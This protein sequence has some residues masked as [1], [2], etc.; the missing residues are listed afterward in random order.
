MTGKEKLQQRLIFLDLDKTLFDT[1]RFKEGL[2][3]IFYECGGPDF[4]GTYQKNRLGNYSFR[5]HLAVIKDRDKRNKVRERVETLLSDSYKFL[6]PDAKDFLNRFKNDHLVLLTRGDKEF[7]KKKIFNLGIN[8]FTVFSQVI[9]TETSKADMV[10]V[11]L[12][13]RFKDPGNVFF[14]DDTA[15]EIADIKNRFDFISCVIVD[16]NGTTSLGKDCPAD[17]VAKDLKEAGDFV[18]NFKVVN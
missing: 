4:Y 9:T 3:K 7:Q 11:V 8:I 13:A 14:I 10:K 18:E 6:F 15:R 16:R 17:F 2:A 5:R 12:P 1:Q